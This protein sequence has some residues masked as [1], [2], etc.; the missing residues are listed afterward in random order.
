[1]N[2][3]KILTIVSESVVDKEGNKIG[4]DPSEFPAITNKCK[5]LVMSRETGLE[6]KVV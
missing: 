1:M 3:T 5:A 6:Y 2:A 4:C